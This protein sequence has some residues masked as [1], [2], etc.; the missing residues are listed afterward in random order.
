MTRAEALTIARE[1]VEKM[2]TSAHGVSFINKVG[3]VD[4][5]A[6]FLVEGIEPDEIAIQPR[7]ELTAQRRNLLVHLAN[8]QLDNGPGEY[9][10][11]AADLLRELGEA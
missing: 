2:A 11:Q 9:D 3:A 10:A 8:N 4:A 6:R 7:H 5:F 1:H